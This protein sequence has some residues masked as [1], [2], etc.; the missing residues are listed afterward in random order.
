MK[1]STKDTRDRWVGHTLDGLTVTAVSYALVSA[2]DALPWTIAAAPVTVWYLV[3]K[4]RAM[5]RLDTL[6]RHPLA[7]L[8]A[9]Q[10]TFGTED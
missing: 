4:L 3:S 5:Y 8:V 7:Y 10:A 2:P 6:L 9:I 1:N